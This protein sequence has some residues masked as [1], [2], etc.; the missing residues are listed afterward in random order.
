MCVLNWF[1][2]TQMS[3]FKKK[4]KNATS[5]WHYNWFSRHRRQPGISQTS[6]LCAEQRLKPN[7]TEAVFH[8]RSAIRELHESAT[9]TGL[10]HINP[11]SYTGA[12]GAH[13]QL[14]V[15]R[16]WNQTSDRCQELLNRQNVPLPTGWE[17]RL[18]ECKPAQK[19]KKTHTAEMR[20]HKCRIVRWANLRYSEELQTSSGKEEGNLWSW[21]NVLLISLIIRSFW[22]RVL[23]FL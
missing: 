12:Q 18:Q 9:C 23:L 4:T 17:G 2:Q 5:L 15:G 8:P 20:A 3:F 16:L 11:F 19:R 22:Q 13:T 14:A 7:P 10:L 1:T 21:G 6:P